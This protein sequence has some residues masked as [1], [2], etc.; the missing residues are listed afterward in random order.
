MVG[1]SQ[2]AQKVIDVPKNLPMFEYRICSVWSALAITSPLRKED[3]ILFTIRV[4]WKIC[5]TK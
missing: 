5:V 1:V 3:S 4:Y 2:A